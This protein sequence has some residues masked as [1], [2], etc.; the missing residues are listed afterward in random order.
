MLKILIFSL[1]LELPS[2]S[3]LKEL[4]HK[5]EKAQKEEQQLA[6]KE[7]SLLAELQAIQKD[8]RKLNHDLRRLE[9]QEL[10]YRRTLR[11]L[12]KLKGTKSQTLH[13]II[14]EEHT[15]LRVWYKHRV[16][17]KASDFTSLMFKRIVNH[18]ETYTDQL[19]HEIER[20]AQKTTKLT[21]TV[22]K[23]R[24]LKRIKAAKLDTLRQ[25]Y[26]EREA[27]LTSIRNERAAKRQLLA[28]LKH[29]RNRLTSF[30]GELTP[31]EQSPSK[32]SF[33]WPLHGKVVA[34]FGLTR[35]PEYNIRIPNPGI[36]ISAPLHTPVRAAATGEVVYADWFRGF[37]KLV[38]IDHKNGWFTVYGYLMELTVTKGTIVRQGDLIGYVGVAPWHNKPTLHFEIR[39][40]SKPIDPL[41]W[42]P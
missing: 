37:G 14:N 24:K 34:R 6:Q 30:I 23:L 18:H 20:I 27:I 13:D 4:T 38:I 25:L 22:N 19:E 31:T 35:D 12:T 9:A 7:Q 8:L 3:Q 32:V 11:K 36:N 40:G 2:T 39:R 42:L 16:T 1:L 10:T 5:I 28:E 33:I 26:E 21:H 15:L 41:K 29:E 17:G